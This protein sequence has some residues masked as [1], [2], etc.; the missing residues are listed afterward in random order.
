MRGH[1]THDGRFPHA[2]DSSA[3]LPNASTNPMHSV[4]FRARSM[5]ASAKAA[6]G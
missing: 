4:T 1:A 6:H 3:T 5:P 2:A